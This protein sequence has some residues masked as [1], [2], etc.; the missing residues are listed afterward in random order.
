MTERQEQD[1]M[2]NNSEAERNQ[3]I[4]HEPSAV[5]EKILQ[6]LRES[7][8]GAPETYAVIDEVRTEDALLRK[9]YEDYNATRKVLGTQKPESL[10]DL[11]GIPT[12]Y[13]RKAGRLDKLD[14]TGDTGGCS[15]KINV[16]TDGE[17]ESWLLTMRSISGNGEGSAA[18]SY[19]SAAAAIGSSIGETL[20]GRACAYSAI[21]VAASAD[22]LA[23]SVKTE[24]EESEGESESAGE[25]EAAA[26]GFSGYLNRTGTAAGIAD[27]IYHPGYSA[28][29][30]ETGAV[31][32]AA[33]AFNVRRDR[34]EAGD[35]VLLIGR[36]V[37]SEDI[38][39][40]GKN[41]P[42]EGRK[43]RRLM[44]NGFAVR[45][46]K[47]CREIGAGGIM[48]ALR[49]LADGFEADLDVMTAEN[50]RTDT[51]ELAVSAL[52]E[53][54]AAVV[55]PENVE[56]FVSFA[57]D[58]GLRC[59]QLAALTGDGK[60]VLRSRGFRVAE[61]TR[62][63]LEPTIPVR[64]ISVEPAAPGDW[65]QTGILAGAAPDSS[66]TELYCKVAADIN[67]CS[68]RGLAE[69]FD[70]TVGTGAVM[71]PFGGHNQ[72]TPAQAAV[73]R[74]PVENGHTDD[75]TLM[76]W[77]FNPYITER[78]PYHGAYLAVVE[79]AAKLTAA[80]GNFEDVYLSFRESFPSPGDDPK[81]WGIP[82][83]AMLGAFEA[84]MRLGLGAVDRRISFEDGT[85]GP[86][87]PP[88]V[89]SFAVTTAKTYETV[90]PEFKAAGRSV[91]MLSPEPDKD[92]SGVG[93]G[94]PGPE[95][96][97]KVWNKSAELIHSGRASAAYAPGIGG[98]AAAI[99]KMTYGNGFGFR[100]ADGLTN[101]EIFGDSC[102]SI[103]L[104]LTEEIS[105][106]DCARTPE[107]TYLGRTVEEQCISKGEESIPIGDLLIL[108]EGR[109]ESVF[110]STCDNGI[111]N[112][113]T[114]SYRARSW[115]APIFKRAEPKVL[116]PVFTGTTCE[117]DAAA[118]F[119]EAG[120][121]PELMVIRD[122]NA[123]MLAEDMEAFAEAVRQSQ[124]IFLPGGFGAVTNAGEGAG[125]IT[126]FFRAEAV[127][128]AV[129][130]LLDS[131]DGLMCGVDNGFRAL[132]SLG[133]V[134]YGSILDT[135]SELPEFTCNT[136][137][138]HRSRIVRV[139][140]ASNKSPWLRYNEVGEILT[141]PASHGEGRLVASD[142]LIRKLAI[143]GQIASQYVDIDGN[144]SGDIR[145]NPSGSVQ[146]IEG[147]TSPDGRVLGRMAHPER[148]VSG[149][150]RNVG[151]SYDLRMFENAVKYFR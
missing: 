19:E 141:L 67:I 3:T 81:K 18:A 75:C 98:A 74:I 142:E 146:S 95:A 87:M 62:S 59:V 54:L 145:F 77:G 58:E 24:A 121:K 56:R 61:F 86:D 135:D 15:L 13:L 43:L 91:V 60:T 82:F 131:K 14:I 53:R 100:F 92:D 28:C 68:R 85:A 136:I 27:E 119:R 117:Y 101:E 50:E 122:R 109:L 36:A 20:R 96:L 30:L 12:R 84:Q 128:A 120:A 143:S 9:A 112:P 1:P 40:G 39:A 89:F 118:A 52:P 48:V 17:D 103:I 132:I 63:M 2:L 105:E 64:H 76:A 6:R 144:V 78:S 35:A 72:L 106:E 66:F 21:R 10:H 123:D 149:L 41:D 47:C 127:K 90:S 133:L 139:R 34:P 45:M 134:P 124:I 107:V 73:Q 65:M 116:I 11:A 31:L 80:G 126:S 23:S 151:G 104:E 108:Y 4:P 111:A 97:V 38:A 150:Y 44:H 32:A 94:L 99:M 49:G 42:A 55:A 26:D 8:G 7:A 88:S 147:I 140:V 16:E 46:I 79:S 93:R 130:D 33:P 125:F 71:M 83:A 69:R 37:R 22:P 148:A 113:E 114:Y 138:S 102:G 129:T 57:E 51:A 29:R 5:E 137:G 70:S 115:H 110:P 25:S